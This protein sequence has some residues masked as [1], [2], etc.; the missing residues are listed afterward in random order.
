M[1]KKDLILIGGGSHACACIDVI[2]T[3]GQFNVAGIVDLPEKL[4]QKVLG[5][6]IIAADRDIPALAKEYDCFLISI[7]QIKSPTKRIN[8]YN[9][10]KEFKVKI[11][12]IISPQAYVSSHARIGTGTIVMHHALINAGTVVGNNCIINTKALIEHDCRIGNHCHISTGTIINGCVEVGDK[13]FIGS[14]AVC[15]ETVKIGEKVIVSS[16]SIIM[17]NLPD[18]ILFR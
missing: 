12:S 9:L 2:E 15:N 6:E 5:Y 4:H 18:K 1:K 11:P 8:I 10:L 13:S 3:A 14:G 16:G 7:G 17:Q